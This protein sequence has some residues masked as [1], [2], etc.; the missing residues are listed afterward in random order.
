MKILYWLREMLQ[1]KYCI[2]LLCFFTFI[3][4]CADAAELSN[5][6]TSSLGGCHRFQKWPGD[7]VIGVSFR[8][9]IDNSIQPLLV[10]IPKGYT[11]QKQW[12]LLVTLHGLGDGPILAKEIESMVQIGPYGRGSVW[13]SGIGEK[14]IFESIEAAKKMFNIDKERIYL[15]G[16]SMGAVGTFDLGLKHP[17]KWT[18]CVPICGR[19]SDLRLI[20]NGLHLPFWI[21]TGALDDILLPSYSRKA[22]DIAQKSDLKEWKLTEHKNMGHSFAI[23]FKSVEQWLLT[24]RKTINPKRIQ[25]CTEVPNRAYWLEVSEISRFGQIARIEAVIERQ[26]ISIK[27]ENTA[28]YKL[29]LNKNLI[30]LSKPICIFENE[31]DIFNGFLN[32]DGLFEKET[33]KED[34]IIKKQGFTGPLWDVYSTSSVLVYGSKS[35]KKSLIE[36]AK[37]CAHNFTNPAW[38]EHVSFEIIPDIAVTNQHISNYNLVLF[39]NTETNTILHEIADKLP[40]ELKDECI[41]VNG[42]EFT[43]EDIGFVLICPNP[44]NAHKYVAVFAGV[45]EKAIDCFGKIWPCFDSVPKEIDYGV[46][47]I[48]RNVHDVKWLVRGVFG[49]NWD[50]Q[51][52]HKV[53]WKSNW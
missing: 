7:C 19:C 45:S 3:T 9:R 22:Y 38:L 24:K 48:K 27:S 53:G 10:K 37:H 4:G 8:S 47:E 28:N 39:G 13:Y 35:D 5:K 32:S 2:C 12:P 50:F 52:N 26:T 18:A 14:D 23:N 30:D 21:H 44:L 33:I 31:E 29:H 1:K 6:G 34:A 17:D 41:W 42:R 46:F 25:Y 36:A 20:L 51:N 11:P 16:F 43:G 49:S 15:C 40:I